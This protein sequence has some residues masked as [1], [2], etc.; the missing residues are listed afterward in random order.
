M[1]NSSEEFWVIN[2]LIQK[3]T[4]HRP[5]TTAHSPQTTDHRRRTTDALWFEKLS[6]PIGTTELKSYWK[7]CAFLPI[8]PYLTPPFGPNP[9][10]DFFEIGQVYAPYHYLF[11]MPEIISQWHLKLELFTK[12]CIF[13]LTG[14]TPGVIGPDIDISRHLTQ[15]LLSAKNQINRINIF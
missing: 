15:I 6:L 4:D 9:W 12:I 14:P 8:F 5:Q 3:F 11:F 2:H 13:S 10:P 7:K 1:P